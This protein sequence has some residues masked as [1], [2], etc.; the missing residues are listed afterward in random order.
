MKPLP[1]K[2]LLIAGCIVTLIVLFR[3]LELQEYLTLDYIKQQQAHFVQLYMANRF[4]VIAVYMLVYIVVTTL[5]LPGS[6]IMTLAG[7]GMFGLTVGTVVVSFASS[8]GATLA[9]MVARY[10]LRDWVQN[11][12]RER[13]IKI[14]AGMAREGGFY[15]FSLR[16]VP[17]FPFFVIN[18]VMGLTSIRIGT[19]YWVTQVGMLPANIVFVNAGKQLASIHSPSDI[20]SLRLLLSFALLGLLPLASRKLLNL[21][22]ARRACRAG[23]NH[24][25][26]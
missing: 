11:T 21:Y 3:V 1:V 5:S 6:A 17:I 24:G 25:R 4:G 10:L 22:K 26:I 7:G 2:K 18:L 19:Y 16:L 20:L 23:N 9:C 13:L 15:L 12:F 8:I 14:N